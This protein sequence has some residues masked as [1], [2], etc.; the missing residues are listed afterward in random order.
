MKTIHVQLCGYSRHQAPFRHRFDKGLET[1]VIRLQ[2]VGGSRAL[3]AGEWT[4]L[5]PGDLLLF[6]PGDIYDLRIGESGEP[7]K[8]NGDYFILGTGEG[9]DEWWAKRPRPHKTTIAEDGRIKSLWHQ[10]NMEKRRLD[11]GDPE[12]V[13]LLAT[14]LLALLDRAIDEAA[15]GAEFAAALHALRMRNYIEEN[16][17][18]PIRL[19]DVARAAGLSVSRAVHLFKAHFGVSIIG[20]VQQLRLSHA[21]ELLLYSPMTLEQIAVESGL[22][23]YTYF[24]RLF[25]ERYGMPPGTYRKLHRS[26]AAE[27]QPD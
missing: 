13:T 26:R 15:P 12:L 24:H 3:V 20:Y 1:Y 9:L 14:A 22:G 4:D 10:L 6:K 18:L 5:A 27:E 2:A 23:S 8:P 25:R 21:L 19:E 11:G 7:M 17:A 16:A